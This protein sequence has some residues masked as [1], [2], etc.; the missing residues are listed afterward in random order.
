MKEDRKAIIGGGLSILRALFDLLGI[1]SLQLTS[2]G[3]RH[4]LLMD[5]LG[6]NQ[7]HS[8]LRT[9]SVERLAAKFGADPVHGKRVGQVASVLLERLCA[10]MPQSAQSAGRGL[11]WFGWVVQVNLRNIA[12]SG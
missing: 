12:L 7:H 6:Q 1:D 10:N 4:G 3:L 9:H 5:M 2:G 8:D 11:L